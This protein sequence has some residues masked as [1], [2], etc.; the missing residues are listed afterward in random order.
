[1]TF[2]RRVRTIYGKELVDLLRD[3]R[4]LI[5]MIVVPIFLY[6]VL[7]LGSLQAI[8]V[9]TQA[10]G[11]R[12]IIVAGLGGADGPQAESLAHL[13][14]EYDRIRAL[15]PSATPASKAPAA[16]SESAPG[17]A[18]A[19]EVEDSAASPPPLQLSWT[20]CASVEE[21]EQC[22]RDRS[23]HV[24]VVFEEGLTFSPDRRNR[25]RILYDREEP[26]SAT[27]HARLE[28][29]IAR[30]AARINDERREALR[31]PATYFDPF[32]V[33]ATNLASPS[34][35][36]GQILPLILVL[37]TITGAI[38]PAIDI[39]AGERE[40]GTLET[41]LACPVPVIDLI[42]GKFL[43]VATIAILG[44][45][46]NLGSVCATVYFGGFN[47][48]IATAG[49]GIPYGQLALILLCLIP[50]AVLMSAIMMAVCSYAR[51]FK[52]AQNYVTPVILAV[53]IPGGF[54]ALPA[55]ELR[56]MML[57]VP[58]GNMVLL[59]RELLIGAPVGT[60]ELLTVLLS[61][62]LYAS[63]AVAVAAKVFGKESVVFADVESLRSTFD[64]R[65]IQ[66]SPRPSLTM[67]L[68]VTAVL[69]PAWFF[70]QSWLQSTRGAENGL[71]ALRRTFAAMP[72]MFV[73]VPALVA[74]Y[75]KVDLRG[76]FGLGG[77]S[78]RAWAGAVLLGMSSWIVA[79]EMVVFQHNWFGMSDLA[80]DSAAALER[81][82]RDLSPVELVILLGLIPAVCEEALFR[83][84]LLG[85][86]RS[87]V[88]KMTAIA[89][90]A[91]VF[92]V[93]HFIL[94]KLPVTFLLGA[95]L[96][97]VC[98]TT[99]SILPGVIVHFMHNTILTLS[100]AHREWFSFLPQ[101]QEGAQDHLPA[102]VVLSAIA[103][104]TAGCVLIGR[105]AP[106]ATGGSAA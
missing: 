105:S 58:V 98:W 90:S 60:S 80:A 54:A 34:S 84:F 52:E 26:R 55:T 101:P 75:W 36:L 73:A 25:I 74:A 17:D 14:Y 85:A 29:V 12:A 45:A 8:T 22:V 50:F 72:V 78:V 21:I 61:T 19:A 28:D 89:A 38:Y 41:I 82:L 86:M 63:A 49:Q 103:I 18:P 66:P 88:R 57:V 59:T 91:A 100:A 44:A 56:G 4:T 106:K 97:W 83:G 67:A 62:T 102:G 6:P 81:L 13:Q 23:A 35:I 27:A 76:A 68:V 47:E 39:T 37:M 32:E 16:S 96:G 31:L 104:F 69:F 94:A 20:P 11:Q 42:V 43:V 9:Q 99:R 79:R 87:G 5:A 93:F 15:E 51:T 7:M 64:R 33:T 24:G 92:A 95:M 46:L 53:L 77:A 40:R 2:R 30:V 48:L 70:L 65:L 3:R 1:M 10:L 71:G